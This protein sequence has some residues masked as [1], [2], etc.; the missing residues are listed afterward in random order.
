MLVNAHVWYNKSGERCM[1]WYDFREH[2]MGGA[3]SRKLSTTKPQE[4]VGQPA[5]NKFSYRKY[6]IGYRM[7]TGLRL[8]QKNRYNVLL[9]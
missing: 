7:K 6:H 4:K 5:Y 8:K 9:P 3:A 2:M 1:S